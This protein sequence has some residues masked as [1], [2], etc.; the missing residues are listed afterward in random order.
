V[1]QV[2]Y[3]G[4]LPNEGGWREHYNIFLEP[5]TASFDRPDAARYRGEGSTVKG[6]STYEWYLNLT[7]AEGTDF[8]KVNEDGEPL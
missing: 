6:K 1:A 7:L 2:P 3:L 4:V 8:T 5:C